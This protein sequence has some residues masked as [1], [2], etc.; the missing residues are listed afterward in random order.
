VIVDYD[1]ND[2]RDDNSISG[3]A[4]LACTLPTPHDDVELIVA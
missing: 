2:D 3:E 1:D 4:P